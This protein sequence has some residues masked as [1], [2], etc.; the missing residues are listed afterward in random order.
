MLPPPGKFIEHALR[1]R[2]VYRIGKF[3]PIPEADVVTLVKS[4]VRAGPSSFNVQSSRV[5]MLFGDSHTKLWRDVV[6]GAVRKV[7]DDATY[8]ESEQRVMNCFASG[9]GTVLFFEDQPTIQKMK[10]DYPKYA[11]GFQGYSLQSSAMAQY[12]VWTALA[13]HGIG[14]SLQHYNEIIEED[15]MKTFQ[16]NPNWKLVSQMPFGNIVEPPGLKMNIPDEERFVVK[17]LRSPCD[18]GGPWS[19]HFIIMI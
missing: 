3:L 8:Q 1:R 14:A 17:G 9:A 10:M 7:T 18:L 15:V 6:L 5:A 19:G 16:L 13:E 11:S 2:T 4:V 12:A